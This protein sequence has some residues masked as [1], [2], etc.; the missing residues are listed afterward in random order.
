VS[1]KGLGLER[2]NCKFKGPL[3]TIN[4]LWVE[5]RQRRI[6]EQ[7]Q[8]Q[9]WRRGGR[10]K[11]KILLLGQRKGRRRTSLKVRGRTEHAGKKGRDVK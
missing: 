8:A 3:E 10:G 4:G 7:R 5:T 2:K 9:G 11:K 1:P 6:I